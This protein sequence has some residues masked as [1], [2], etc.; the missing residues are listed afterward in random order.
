MPVEWELKMVPTGKDV[1]ISHFGP[2]IWIQM[3]KQKY[4]PPM[5]IRNRRLVLPNSDEVGLPEVFPSDMPANVEFAYRIREWVGT[6][7]SKKHLFTIKGPNVSG[8][9]RQLYRRL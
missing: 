1:D 4:L 9:L 7:S 2:V 8:R 5:S 3:Q 6:E